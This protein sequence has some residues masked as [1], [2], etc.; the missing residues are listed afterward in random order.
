MP[1]SVKGLILTSPVGGGGGVM[2]SPQTSGGVG[3]PG[4]PPPPP[5]PGPDSPITLG[6]WLH[7]VPHPRLDH[8]PRLAKGALG[9]EGSA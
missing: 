7:P 2:K 3:T 6:G 1:A 4:P 5:R 8:R 9:E